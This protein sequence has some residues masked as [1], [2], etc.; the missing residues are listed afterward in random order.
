V[1][2]VDDRPGERVGQGMV[3]VGGRG[4]PARV[5]AGWRGR[6]SACGGGAGLARVVSRRWR[7]AGRQWGGGPCGR[8][9]AACAAAGRGQRAWWRGG[10]SPC[11][12]AG[13]SCGGAVAACVLL[14]R[15]RPVRGV[16]QV[17]PCGGVGQAERRRQIEWWGGVRCGGRP[18]WRPA[19]RRRGAGP[20]G[21]A[22][23]PERRRAA[24]RV[25]RRPAEAVGR[26]WPVWRGGCGAI[27]CLGGTPLVSFCGRIALGAHRSAPPDCE[28]D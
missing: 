23:Q 11:G 1:V 10:G 2:K 24:H 22:G 17:S 18:E 14:G 27:G 28:V 12:G 26:S 3:D 15:W 6:G 19:G 8:A 16:G 13:R 25:G 7:P 5:V 9:V 21:R 4:E 20:C